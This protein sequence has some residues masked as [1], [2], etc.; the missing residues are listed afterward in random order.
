M[1]LYLFIEKTVQK[2]PKYVQLYHFLRIYGSLLG[3][4]VYFC[5][6]GY[7][8]RNKLKRICE[9]QRVTL[10][11]TGRGVTQKWV[12]DHIIYPQYFISLSTFYE[13]LATPA[14]RELNKMYEAEAQQLSMF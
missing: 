13:Y 2:C 3:F 11:H 14:R 1:A 4:F 8:K 5:V 12:Y 10:E 9:I 7:N 6:M